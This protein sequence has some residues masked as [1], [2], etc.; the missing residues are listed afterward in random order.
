MPPTKVGGVALRAT[1]A[2]G[3]MA[4]LVREKRLVRRFYIVAPKLIPN[5]SFPIPVFIHF[6][7]YILFYKNEIKKI[8][9]I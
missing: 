8:K 6:F 5:Y 3:R 9:K 1:A 7:L 2:E 4:P